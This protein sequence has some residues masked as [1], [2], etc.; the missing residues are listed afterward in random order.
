MTTKEFD[1]D[2][3][4]NAINNINNEKFVEKKYTEIMKQKNDVL[5][6]LQLKKEELK[7]IHSKLKDYK[8]IDEISDLGYGTYI[9]WIPL[10]T[11]ENIYL[12]NG[13]IVTDIKITQ[14][15][16]LIQTK[17]NRNRFTNISFDNTLIF[18][19]FTEQEKIILN[20][21]KHLES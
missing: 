17:N 8:Y 6:Q 11:P 14:K 4:L 19:K 21:L 13:G 5:Q 10:K 18:Q 12:T 2:K 7:K 1:I 15:G 9:R 20:V 16:L 3:L